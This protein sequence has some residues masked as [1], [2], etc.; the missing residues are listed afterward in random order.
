[1]TLEWMSDAELKA[2]LEQL[3]TD[4]IETADAVP[5]AAVRE[6]SQLRDELVRR[7]KERHRGDDA[8]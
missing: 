5:I 7:L 3:T 8:S 2:R 1:V 4:L 6:R